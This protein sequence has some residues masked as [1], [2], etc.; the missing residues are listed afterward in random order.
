MT[1]ESRPA[2]RPPNN[3]TVPSIHRRAERVRP[4]ER[5]WIN[6]LDSPALDQLVRELVAVERAASAGRRA[7]DAA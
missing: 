1:Q 5:A 3:S 6:S 4:G 2:R 7:R